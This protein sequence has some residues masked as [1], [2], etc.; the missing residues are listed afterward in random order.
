MTN[1]MTN[2][3]KFY[4]ILTFSDLIFLNILSELKHVI[5]K[6]YRNLTKR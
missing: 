5:I 3:V 4:K 6:L 1:E 2:I